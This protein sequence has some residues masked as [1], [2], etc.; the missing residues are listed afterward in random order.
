MTDSWP[1]EENTEKHRETVQDPCLLLKVPFER[2]EDGTFQ[3]KI[4]GTVED[5]EVSGETFQCE[6]WIQNTWLLSGTCSRK[7]QP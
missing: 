6:K 4:P 1:K 5:G 3:D 7:Q 2:N